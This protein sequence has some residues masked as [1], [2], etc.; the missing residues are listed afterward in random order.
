MKIISEA[1]ESVIKILNTVDRFD[2][3]NRLLTYCVE[4]TTGRDHLLFN[5]LTREMILLSEEEWNKRLDNKY[6]KEHWFVV[7]ESCKDKEY[8]DLVRWIVS[9]KQKKNKNITAYTIF[10]TTDCNAR[11]FYCFEQG[12]SR[13]P[14]SEETAY[15]VAN[16]IAAHCGG[17]KVS[18]SWFGGEPLF[19]KTVIDIIC[20]NLREKGI[21]YISSMVSNGYLFDRETA[22]TAVENWN[23]RRVQITLDG[24]EIIYNKV[25]A[26]IYKDENPFET[27]MSNI[28]HLLDASIS[29]SI[30]L[31]VDIYNAENLL[32]LV[33]ELAKRFQSKKGL[34]VYAHHLFKGNEPT[35]QLHAEAGWE[36]R[37]LA[38]TRLEEKISQYNLAAKNGIRKSIKRYYCM[39][40]CGYA[41]TILPGGEIGL[42]DQHSES[43]FIGHIDQDQYDMELA[44]SWQEEAPR[45]PECDSCFYY[46]ECF[47]LKKCTNNATCHP[48]VRRRNLK[49]LQRQMIDELEKTEGQ[50]TIEKNQ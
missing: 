9:N 46:P 16:Y 42:C 17:E 37:E 35:A 40:D 2:D 23:L 48:F 43:E 22:A 20:K 50:D 21:E 38:I 5:L 44:R 13:V 49:L 27:V 30:R 34:S 28:G 45:I 36:E 18:I 31:N 32:E 47:T 29:V 24:T 14:M 25:K 7:P 41:I 39:A 12:R 26:Y 11:C 8:A 4:L 6:L 3:T 10:T 19:N 1:N 33:E 15:K